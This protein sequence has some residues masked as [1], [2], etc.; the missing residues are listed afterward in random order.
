V[1]FNSYVSLPEGT[2]N[3]GNEMSDVS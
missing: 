1:I 2:E 3:V